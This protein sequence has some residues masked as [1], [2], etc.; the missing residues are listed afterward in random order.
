M[1]RSV[2]AGSSV[3]CAQCDE[4][5]KFKAK[6]RQQQVIC[7]VYVKGTWDRV[8]HFHAGCYATAG[9]PHGEAEAMPTPTRRAGAGRADAPRASA[10]AA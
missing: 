1:V 2:E 3:S 6:E 4:P 10:P 5:V 7:N 9:S 8:E